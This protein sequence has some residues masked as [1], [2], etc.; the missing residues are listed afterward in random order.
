MRHCCLGNW[1]SEL[2]AGDNVWV[3]FNC[4][5]VVLHLD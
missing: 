3:L 5:A 2:K 1:L 4:F